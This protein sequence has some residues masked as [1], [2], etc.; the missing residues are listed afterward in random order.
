MG[1]E[2]HKEKPDKTN[3]NEFLTSGSGAFARRDLAVE[4]A[5]DQVSR[6]L[7]QLPTAHRKIIKKNTA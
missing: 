7:G 4:Q 6:V 3:N 2:Y 5:S 1:K